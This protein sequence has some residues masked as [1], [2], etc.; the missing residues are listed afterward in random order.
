MSYE[1]FKDIYFSPGL[2][3]TYDDLTTDSTASELLKK[4]AGTSTDLMFDYALSQIK[5]IED[6]CQQRIFNKIFYQELPLIRRSTI[7]IK[8]SFS[9]NHYKEFS[10]DFI[11]ALKFSASAING[12]ND[13]DVRVKSKD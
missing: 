3:L 13:E 6:L 7:Y 2:S 11:G 5:E 1:K 4:Q 9:T 12:L 10:E 8:N